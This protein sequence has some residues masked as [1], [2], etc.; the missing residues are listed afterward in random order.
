ML[1]IAWVT[2]IF[3]R[4]AM[5]YGSRLDSMW[6]GQ[7][8]A[9]LH[10]FWATELGG[11]ETA[12]EVIAHALDNLPEDRPPTLGEFKRLCATA[13]RAQQKRLPPPKPNAEFVAKVMRDM[14]AAATANGDPKAWAHRL[15][16][17]ETNGE[18]LNAAQRV[19]WRSA[20]QP[21]Q[22]AEA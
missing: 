10:R 5:H 18:R 20:I 17:A 4:M 9:A 6:A 2:E 19:M 16:L 7:D 12:P 3:G 8:A 13:P 1:P 14:R 15:R 22:R 21:G 11:L